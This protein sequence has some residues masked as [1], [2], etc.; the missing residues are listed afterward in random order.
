MP[1]DIVSKFFFTSGAAIVLVIATAEI[2]A[3]RDNEDIPDEARKGEIVLLL[4]AIW[5]A[6]CSGVFR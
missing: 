2:L 5:L 4:I 1:S 3:L 6:I